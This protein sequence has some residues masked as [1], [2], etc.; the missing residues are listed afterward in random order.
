MNRLIVISYWTDLETLAAAGKGSLPQYGYVIPEMRSISR[1]DP[2]LDP[3][4]LF[5]PDKVA[6]MV[7]TRSDPVRLGVGRAGQPIKAPVLVQ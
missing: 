2:G 1:F 7:H 6:K 3:F 5:L 4:W